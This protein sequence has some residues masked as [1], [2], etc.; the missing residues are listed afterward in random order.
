MRPEGGGGDTPGLAQQTVKFFCS[1]TQQ[2]L[3]TLLLLSGRV[4]EAGPSETVRINPPCAGC[5]R[6]LTQKLRTW[7]SGG[8]VASIGPL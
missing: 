5:N 2:T 7:A 6:P 1:L 8:F 3:D 4:H